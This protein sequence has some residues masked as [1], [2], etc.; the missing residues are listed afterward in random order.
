MT[1]RFEG[2][3]VLVTGGGSGLG[4]AI[5]HRFAADGAAGIAIVDRVED[6]LDVVRQE[7][8]GYGIPVIPLVA[9]LEDPHGCEAVVERTVAE[10]GSIQVAISNAGISSSG[11]PSMDMT[12]ES[13]NRM[14]AVNLTAYFLIARCSAR[15][16]VRSGGGS[17]LFTSSVG[18]TWGQPGGAHYSAT[19]AAVANLAKTLALEWGAQGIRVNAVSPGGMDTNMI[20][21]YQGEEAAQRQRTGP[22]QAVLGR[23][24]RAEE[25]AAAFAYL[26]SEDASYIT[27]VNLMVDGGVT[28]GIPPAAPLER[29]AR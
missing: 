14:L 10:L 22:V 9:D 17:I 3:N 8:A 23:I 15:H 20:A 13:W 25:V 28:A 11:E 16:M 18:G 24:A 2:V 4:R 6:R 5:A 27:G 19:K 21:E 12:I 7:L 26:A 1:A 29:D